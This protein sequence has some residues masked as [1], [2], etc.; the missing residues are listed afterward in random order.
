MY[1]VPYPVL[2]YISGVY[3]SSINISRCEQG[4]IFLDC[5]SAIP[6]PEDIGHVLLV[7]CRLQHRVYLWGIL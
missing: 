6:H 7:Y 4:I 3:Q 1:R 2:K 5:T